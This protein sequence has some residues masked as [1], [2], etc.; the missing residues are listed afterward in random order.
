MNKSCRS[1]FKNLTGKACHCRRALW[2]FYERIRGSKL[3]E[4]VLRIREI[5][6]FPL[7]N[8]FFGL[9]KFEHVIFWK[10][11]VVNMVYFV[12]SFHLSQEKGFT[13]DIQCYATYSRHCSLLFKWLL[14][15]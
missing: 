12:V 5:E 1:I 7:K 6:Y 2:G 8:P 11:F 15:L 3:R 14:I 13:L 10:F 9:M 4:K